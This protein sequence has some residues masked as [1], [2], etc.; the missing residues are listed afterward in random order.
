[1]VIGAEFRHAHGPGHCCCGVRGVGNAQPCADELDGA[2]GGEPCRCSCHATAGNSRFAPGALP[3]WV[4][5]RVGQSALE[6][7]GEIAGRRFGEDQD[8]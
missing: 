2:P 3:A 5:E 1:M 7:A 8:D 4:F 6:T